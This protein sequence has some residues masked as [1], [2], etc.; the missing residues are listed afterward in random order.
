MR[1]T[2]RLLAPALLCV[3]A[4]NLHAATLIESNTARGTQKMWVEGTRA[5]VENDAGMEGYILMDFSERQLLFVNDGEKT[6]V[7]MGGQLSD[8]PPPQVDGA[9]LTKVGPGPEIAGYETTH[10]R[11]EMEGKVCSDNY[12]SQTVVE[13]ADLEALAEAAK[14]IYSPPAPRNGDPC[15]RA[16][17]AFEP[18]LIEKGFVLRS[19]KDGKVR[20]EVTSVRT[21]VELPPGGME[22]PP[23]YERL[24][25]AEM[26]RRMIESM[27][28][29]MQRSRHS[30]SEQ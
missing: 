27:K 24:D 30:Q 29:Q 25:L 2:G 13:E 7:T 9:R 28:Q 16:E 18:K 20:R 12:V 15:V 23:D 4:P 8:A 11:L 1:L 6:I 5:R 26:Q 14:E 21:G 3:L 19:V 10:Y 17:A 22:P